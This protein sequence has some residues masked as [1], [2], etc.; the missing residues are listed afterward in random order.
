MS[1]GVGVAMISL[2][3]S[4]TLPP[5]FAV[6]SALAEHQA[7]TGRECRDHVDRSLAAVLLVGPARRGGVGRVEVVFG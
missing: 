7:L 6:G 4:A 3:F 5:A 2:D 1:S